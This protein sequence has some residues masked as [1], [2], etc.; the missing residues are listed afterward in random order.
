MK[1]E[2]TTIER[3]K[4]DCIRYHSAD[5]A[6]GCCILLIILTHYGFSDTER[7]RLLFPFWVDM[8][9][10]IFMVISGFVYSN[11]L[12][13]RGIVAFE[14]SYHIELLLDRVFRY[15]VPFFI[16][17]ILEEILLCLFDSIRPGIT[18]V[19]VSFLVGGI[20]LGSYYYPIMVQL[21]F[22]FPI[23]Y[24]IVHKLE[25][26]GVIICG[27]INIFYEVLK[28]AYGMNEDC[29][30]LLLFRYILLIAYGCYLSL[31]HYKKNIK[32]SFLCFAIGVCYIVTVQYLKVS[33]IVTNYWSGTCIW[34][35]LFLL[36][37]VR[38]IVINP[39]QIPF[40]ESIGKASYDIFLV[41][42]VYYRFFAEVLYRYVTNR[43]MQVLINLLICVAAGKLFYRIETPITDYVNEKFK[44]CYRNIQKNYIHSN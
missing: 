2:F 38:Y 20:G 5:I 31:N 30:R 26:L 16:A 32:L 35:V 21:V 11:S 43:G 13:K 9:V 40:I 33:P 22:F 24:V 34:A 25:F 4:K 18:D 15:S 19:I 17:F 42:M 41:Q 10:P 6:K 3:Q 29:Y 27:L 28:T 14:D 37:I 44:S 7:L 12:K 1:K 36:P 39:M 8:A 23:I